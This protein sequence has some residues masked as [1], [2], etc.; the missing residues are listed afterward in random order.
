M[1]GI[2]YP[3][4]AHLNIFTSED[5]KIY[6]KAIVGITESYMHDLTRSKWA[7]FYQ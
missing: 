2:Q 5:L 7:D 3:Y 6:N 1:D 4:L